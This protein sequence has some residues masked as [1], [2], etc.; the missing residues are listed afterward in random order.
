MHP[1]SHVN[2][3]RSSP[4]NRVCKARPAGDREP[5]LKHLPAQTAP[6]QVRAAQNQHPKELEPSRL[7]A[8]A[9]NTNRQNIP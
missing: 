5:E 6:P 2:V 4:P 1:A 7:Q 8:L 9:L 3:N